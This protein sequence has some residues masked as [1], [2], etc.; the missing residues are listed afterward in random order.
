MKTILQILSQLP[1][2]YVWLIFLVENV[3]ITCCVLFLGRFFYKG[4]YTRQEWGICAVTNLLNTVITYAG[5]WLWQHQV[6]IVATGGGWRILTDFLMLFAAMD[7][8]MFLFHVAIHKSFLYKMVHSLHHEAVDPKPIDLFVLH[9][10]ETLG[11][12]SLWLLLLIVYPFDIT[13]IAVYLTVNVVFGLAGH[14][15]VEPLPDKVRQWPGMKYLGTSTFH[16]NH[17]QHVQYNFGFY[18]NLWDKLFNTFKR[19]ENV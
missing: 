19:E 3:L 9:P 1:V 17:H 8:L 6:I 4:K 14:L 12:G 7:L 10:V 18:T 16:H 15:G 2:G 13:G 5:F 11:F